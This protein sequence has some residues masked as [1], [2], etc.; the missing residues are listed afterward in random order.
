MKVDTIPLLLSISKH[1]Y[2]LI[3]G[4]FEGQKADNLMTVMNNINTLYQYCRFHITKSN[5]DSE[6]EPICEEMLDLG[7]TLNTASCDEHAPKAEQSDRTIKYQFWSVLK[8]GIFLVILIFLQKY[9][10]G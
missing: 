6:F 2:F 5:M 8:T 7:I 10:R 3:V 4:F 9:Y 1:L